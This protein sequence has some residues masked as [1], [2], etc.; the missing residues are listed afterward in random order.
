MLV[1]TW[2]ISLK[3]SMQSLH[4]LHPMIF[5]ADFWFRY[6]FQK[7]FTLLFLYLSSVKRFY[8]KIN[9]VLYLLFSYFSLNEPP[10]VCYVC[11]LSV[12]APV[13]GGR[14]ILTYLTLQ[15]KVFRYSFSKTMPRFF[16][17][18]KSNFIIT[19]P[20]TMKL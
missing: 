17:S 16:K 4:F 1:R 13:K 2:L 12:H 8:T 18:L 14:T 3:T 6:S 11:F 10:Y 5:V 19:C 15:F 20:I 7:N 9:V